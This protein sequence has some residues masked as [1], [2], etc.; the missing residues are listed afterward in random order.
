M[1]NS[2][3]RSTQVLFGAELK[4][5]GYYLEHAFYLDHVIFTN[6]SHVYYLDQYI[7]TRGDLFPNLGNEFVSAKKICQTAQSL[8]FFLSNFQYGLFTFGTITQSG[9][10]ESKSKAT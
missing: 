9:M 5:R 10:H 2:F 1:L 3:L 6:M 4:P 8:E 7:F